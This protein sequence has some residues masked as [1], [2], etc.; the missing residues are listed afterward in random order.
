MAAPFVREALT[1]AS[2]LPS[3]LSQCSSQ[4][5]EAKGSVWGKVAEIPHDGQFRKGNKTGR[6]DVLL[7]KRLLYY[8]A[9][10]TTKRCIARGVPHSELMLDISER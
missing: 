10:D 4:V 2:E 9:L 1:S 7:R 5:I 6:F 8:K 3:A